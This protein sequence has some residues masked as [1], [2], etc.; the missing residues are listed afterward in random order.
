MYLSIGNIP[1][2]VRRQVSSHATVLIGYIPVSKLECFSAGEPRRY[3]SYR[4]YHHCMTQILKPL[5]EA[6]TSGVSMVCA[7]GGVRMVFPILA[8]Y[9]ADH[10]EQCLVTNVQE[11]H[12]PKGKIRPENRGDLQGCVPRSVNE[13]LELLDSHRRGETEEE[14]PDGLRPVYSPFWQRLPHCDIFSCITPD[15]LHQ[16]HKGVFKDHL[17]S[18]ITDLVGSEELDRRFKAMAHIPGLRHFKKGISSV[19]QWTGTE[20][21][22]MQKVFLT[23]VAGAVDV[24]VLTVI[25]AVI[26]FIYH[27]QLQVHTSVTLEALQHALT[28]F[29]RH[30]V[31]L[32]ELGVR[33]HFNI[34]KVHSMT[35]Y[36][37]SIREKGC[38]DGFNT[39]LSERLHIDFAKQGYRA[40]NR[41]DYI[42]HMTKWL[43]RQEAVKLRIAYLSWASPSASDTEADDVR[44]ESGSESQHSATEDPPVAQGKKEDLRFAPAPSIHLY[45]IAKKCPTPRT[46]LDSIERLHGALQFLPAFIAFTKETFPRSAQIPTHL[47]RYNT[48]KKLNIRQPWN[49]VLGKDTVVHRVRASPPSSARGRLQ[50]VAGRFDPVIVIEDVKQY[51][52]SPPGSLRGTYPH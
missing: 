34:A 2:S 49:P 37:D 21:K 33:N 38:A 52:S 10:P 45:S 18:W 51:R 26:D 48:Y 7:D 8:A 15:F 47:T 1:K 46:K 5:V 28:I 31:V 9:V 32:V 29:H 13:T 22:Q 17:V 23:L 20:Y 11:N 40:G 4:L 27:A 43:V 41:R 12:C 3:A 24:R 39:E 19:Q 36:A 44:S 14:L 35:H 50:E 6:G 30:K 16:L 42:A 25:Q